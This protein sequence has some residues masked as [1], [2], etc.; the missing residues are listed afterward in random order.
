[1]K[2]SPFIFYA[3]QN[4]GKPAADPQDGRQHHL[5]S[6]AHALSGEDFERILNNVLK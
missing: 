4:I 3:M 1:M 2:I 5:S 6:N